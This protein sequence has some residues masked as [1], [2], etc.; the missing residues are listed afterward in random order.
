VF[1]R[2]TLFGGEYGLLN[3]MTFQPT[4]GFWI[5]LLHKRLMGT[6]VLSTTPAASNRSMISAYAHCARNLTGGIA[7]MVVNLNSESV[8]LRLPA[9]ASRMEWRLEADGLLATDVR[10]NGERLVLTTS[11]SLPTMLGRPVVGGDRP[12]SVVAGYSMLWAVLEGASG[13]AACR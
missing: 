7:L 9:H 3:N 5:A 8:S 11:G 13:A 10:L 2:Q 12:A 1:A 6:A 4:P